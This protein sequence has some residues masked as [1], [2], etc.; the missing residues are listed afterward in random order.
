MSSLATVFVASVDEIG[1]GWLIERATSSGCA[2]E[3]VTLRE[4]ATY[5]GMTVKRPDPSCA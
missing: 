1:T 2:T 4:R 3:A 5:P